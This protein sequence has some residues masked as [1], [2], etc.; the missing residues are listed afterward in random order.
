LLFEYTGTANIA[1]K[2]IDA[3][4]KNNLHSLLF[5]KVRCSIIMDYW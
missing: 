1:K 2:N 5:A 3:A 4:I